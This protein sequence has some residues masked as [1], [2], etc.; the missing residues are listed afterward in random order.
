MHVI[1]FLASSLFLGLILLGCGDN[2][3]TAPGTENLEILVVRGDGQFG[4]PG[5]LLPVPLEVRVQTLS[6]GRG[7][8]GITVQW[9]VLEGEGAVL[10]QATSL[11]DSTG[12]TSTTLTLGSEL[13]DY[14]VRASVG[15]MVS[16][17]VEFL[18]QAIQNPELT[19]VPEDPVR[20][21]DTIQVSGRNL[22]TNPDENVVTFSRIRGRVLTATSTEL[23]VEVP[24]CLP[25]RAVEVRVHIGTVTTNALPLQVLEG[26]LFFTMDRGDDLILEA[27]E[28][29][30]CIRLPSAPG[31]RYLVVPHT[32][33]TVGGAVYDFGL[34]GLAENPLSGAPAVPERAPGGAH[35]GAGGEALAAVDRQ[36]AWDARLRALEGEA[37][38]ERGSDTGGEG[39]VRSGREERTP[40]GVPQVGDT[41]EFNVLN[42][43]NEFDKVT[44][45]IEHITDHAVIY[46]D[47]DTPSG[48]FTASDLAALAG[49][50]EWPIYPTIT[51]AFGS[52]SDLDGNGRVVILLTPAVNRLT[53]DGADSYVGGYFFGV[54]LLE[55]RT[56]SNKAE[57]FYAV[58]PD[59]TGI[60]GPVLSRTTLLYAVPSILAHE[61][62]HMVHFN[63]RILEAGAGDQDALWLSE[64][65]AQMAE[66]LVGDAYNESGDPESGLQY[67]SGNWSRARRFLL[68]S[69]NVSVLAT[70]PP[71]TLAER[72]AGWLLLKYLFGQD[73]SGTLLRSLSGSDLTGV[74][75]LTGVVG[76]SWG[77]IVSDW[78]GA[79]FLDGTAV[80]VR[81]SLRVLGVNLREVLA[82]FDGR[83]PLN[84]PEMGASSFSRTG[85]LWSSAPDYYII[86]TPEGGGLALNLSGLEGRPPHPASGLRFLLVRLQ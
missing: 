54:D 62:E 75:N 23:A 78:T 8:D 86:T 22:S 17:P 63:R 34:V 45:R 13:G 10:G 33:G 77:D 12:L 55:D 18:A 71:G 7:E 36:W 26:D 49:E 6:T 53:P 61:F 19:T 50:F 43:E 40:Q 47:E 68:N 58:V 41:R 20:A 69:N 14:R 84:P 80:P 46:L 5:A 11:T 79:L 39:W 1:R 3:F 21:G 65:L 4:Q 24:A 31:A 67:Q 76:R 28:G 66:D 60:H 30:A 51:G 32:T 64:A 56:G 72:G 16:P 38:R 73:E 83:Y 9:K 37:L 52:E 44:A 48:G 42:A 2:L 27:T 29:F 85:S 74:E 25:S 57:I 59:P 82:R 70:L 35:A 81:L 15:G